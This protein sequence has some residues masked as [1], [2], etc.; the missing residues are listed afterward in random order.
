MSEIRFPT[1]TAGHILSSGPFGTGSNPN[2]EFDYS[3]SRLIIMQGSIATQSDISSNTAS[4][5]R[6]SDRLVEFVTTN[7][8]TQDPNNNSVILGEPIQGTASQSGTATWFWLVAYGAYSSASGTIVNQLVG[9]VSA[10]AGGG[11]L[12]V[13]STSIVN[14]Q[15][16]TLGQ[17]AFT[18]PATFTSA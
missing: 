10:A 1:V 17:I 3:G 18:L 16:Y 6:T 11:D 2:Y 7:K 4:T 13:N 9:T 5:F 15:T 14:G 8:W 12:V